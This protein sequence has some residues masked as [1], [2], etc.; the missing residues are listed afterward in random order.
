MTTQTYSTSSSWW[1]SRIHA[2]Q[3]AIGPTRDVPHGKVSILGDRWNRERVGYLSAPGSTLKINV[4]AAAIGAPSADI[5]GGQP[6]ISVKSTK[7][8]SAGDYVYIEDNNANEGATIF[9]IVDDT[10]LIM[11]GNITG[12]YETAE[13]SFVSSIRSVTLEKNTNFSTGD[14]VSFIKDDEQPHIAEVYDIDDSGTYDTILKVL[15]LKKD[16]KKGDFCY[17]INTS[18]GWAR[19]SSN[20]IVGLG[21]EYPWD[22]MG[23]N[24]SSCEVLDSV[25]VEKDENDKDKWNK[26]GM[27]LTSGRENYSDQITLLLSSEENDYYKWTPFLGTG[28]LSR[29]NPIIRHCKET[30][31]FSYAD[32]DELQDVWDSE[33]ATLTI[34]AVGTTVLQ[35]AYTDSG[36]TWG[37]VPTPFNGDI[38]TDGD[39]TCTFRLIGN[40]GNANGDLYIKLLAADG[41]SFVYNFDGVL[42][43]T[44]SKSFDIDTDVFPG[45]RYLRA[46][47]VGVSMASPGAGT[48]QIDDMKPFVPAEWDEIV[49]DPTVVSG[50]NVD[51]LG[52]FICYYTARE[53]PRHEMT[54]YTPGSTNT[55][56]DIASTTD[57]DVGDTVVLYDMDNYEIGKVDLVNSGTRLTV[58]HYAYD[59]DNAAF[60]E[61]TYSTS[62]LARIAN[63]TYRV[64]TIGGAYIL[65]P[66]DTSNWS[67]WRTDGSVP[68]IEPSTTA[69]DWDAGSVSQPSAKFLGNDI[70]LAYVGTCVGGDSS[71]GFAKSSNFYSFT[72]LEGNPFI[73]PGV[74]EF[75]SN[76]CSH[77]DLHIS[78]PYSIVHYSGYDGTD[79][80]IGSASIRNSFHNA[81]KFHVAM[82]VYPCASLGNPPEDGS[83]LFDM[84]NFRIEVDQNN[85]L[86][87]YAI[88]DGNEVWT[89]A[90]GNWNEMQQAW[91]TYLVHDRQNLIIAQFAGDKIGIHRVNMMPHVSRR[92]Y[93]TQS[94]WM[95]AAGATPGAT[96][97]NLQRQYDFIDGVTD[98][99]GTGQDILFWGL[100][101]TSGGEQ[102]KGGVYNPQIGRIVGVTDFGGGDL[103]QI[104][105]A[106]PIG[107]WGYATDNLYFS[108]GVGCTNIGVMLAQ[109]HAGIVSSTTDDN[110][111]F[112]NSPSGDA[113]KLFSDSIVI[114]KGEGLEGT[115]ST[116]G[117]T[118][119]DPSYAFPP[120]VGND[121]DGKR[122]WKYGYIEHIDIGTDLLDYNVGSGNGGRIQ[123]YKEMIFQ[124][125]SKCP[126]HL[127]DLQGIGQ[128]PTVGKMIARWD[129]EGDWDGTKYGDSSPAGNN[130]LYPTGSAASNPDGY[131]GRTALMITASDSLECL[132]FNTNLDKR[133]AGA[134]QVQSSAS[135]WDSTDVIAP[136]LFLSNS[137]WKL[138][139]TGKGKE[140]YRAYG[141][142]TGDVFE[143]SSI[144]A[145]VT[146]NA[147]FNILTGTTATVYLSWQKKTSWYEVWNS[148]TPGTQ[149]MVDQYW[150]LPGTTTDYHYNVRWKVKLEADPTYV[151]SPII[152]SFAIEYTSPG[153]VPSAA[154]LAAQNSATKTPAKKIQ[155]YIASGANL[156][157]KIDITGKVSNIGNIIQE[158]PVKPD[159]LGDII[160]GN[161]I[162][163]VDNSDKYFSELVASSVF[164]NRFILDDEIRIFS[165]FNLS[166]RN[167]YQV[168]GRYLIDKVVTSNQ[169]IAYIYCSSLLRESLD[170]IIGEPVN[171]EANPK[172]YEGTWKVKKLMEDLLTTYANL[173]IENINIEDYDR[174]FSNITIEN[175]TVKYVIQRL[176]QACDGVIYTDNQGD[177]F[178]KTWD[179]MSAGT[180]EIKPNR[181]LV[182]IKVTGQRRDRY[183]I[184]AI[185]TGDVGIQGEYDSGNTT[186]RIVTI[187]NEY[188]QTEAIANT[189][190]QNTVD[191]NNQSEMEL[192]LSS[193]YLPSVKI[194]DTV[195]ITDTLSG[196]SATPFLVNSID[197]DVSSFSDNYLLTKKLAVT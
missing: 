179:N 162:I 21:I 111:L 20:P 169:P 71:I 49:A 136:N 193:C 167:E 88:A 129:L 66:V 56:V 126:W 173:N 99:G 79:K 159:K 177:I 163:T 62:K 43:T 153:A 73:E 50:E 78:M 35:I 11:T 114:S 2:F 60:F 29:P 134:S 145:G 22:N 123:L 18:S 147:S 85:R 7:N 148:A 132:L 117:N 53:R 113:Y 24:V 32:T 94:P 160:P 6:N 59:E 34:T 154:F 61:H 40:V 102:Y 183:V 119:L 185:V 25:D 58:K 46:V 105:L 98:F 63:N 97:I 184:K 143:A 107:A 36:E 128:L 37:I 141:E 26:P 144:T 150:A 178:F 155:L 54:A 9:S 96:V 172:V 95:L 8:F 175:K 14:L 180:Y 47:I 3:V 182:T 91:G 127:F 81:D 55:V 45:W 176:A 161:I 158:I 5:T 27:F 57:F 10:T 149:T 115:V 52:T 166:G 38:R 146:I 86:W 122:A 76:G 131:M 41:T 137:G 75:D 110:Q 90:D 28:N 104:T 125:A 138:A 170:K 106:N 87:T 51:A 196:L 12:T 135:G 101:H 89:T 181:N 100:A 168:S 124:N 17:T 19:D 44:A 108:K 140:A 72:R 186:G 195:L 118:I 109:G 33:D 139:Y 164:Y 48:I 187:N 1:S 194:L 39:N 152:N 64:N 133:N 174:S 93:F 30:E 189:I 121:I 68:V 42:I 171:N 120:I 116:Q 92:E 188:V 192:D 197:K 112:T 13:N 77:P 65:D 4:D 31:E 16:V 156:G 130:D 190:A 67:K 69:T 191:R 151:N 103:F 70:Y 83:V 84:G 142:V 157:N 74:G 82:L 165:G 15:R 80:T 23:Q